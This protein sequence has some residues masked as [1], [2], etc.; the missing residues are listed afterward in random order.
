MSTSLLYCGIK[1]HSLNECS[2]VCDFVKL[3][4]GHLE[5]TLSLRF[6]HGSAFHYREITFVNINIL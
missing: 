5:N 2:P 6:V 4:I 3:H 1:T